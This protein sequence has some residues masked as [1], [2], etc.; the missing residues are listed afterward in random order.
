MLCCRLVQCH[1]FGF[2]ASRFGFL[3]PAEE[4]VYRPVPA[5]YPMM[6]IG[7]NGK[8]IAM[9]FDTFQRVAHRVV[10]SLL[11]WEKLL[12]MKS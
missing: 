9:L 5:A 7:E 12:W 6:Q 3:H 11:G 2:K 8:I 4:T 10:Q 1:V